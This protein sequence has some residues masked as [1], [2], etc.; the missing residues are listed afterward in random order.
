MND[1]KQQSTVTPAEPEAAPKAKKAKAAKAPAEP[2]AP[3][4]PKVKV[5]ETLL[6]ID[7]GPKKLFTG[8]RLTT[9]LTENPRKQG[10]VGHANFQH[11]ID[12]G[13]AG[14]TTEEYLEK[15]GRYVDLAWDYQRGRVNLADA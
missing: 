4:E 15:G 7:G 12:A 3:K 14:I 13:A 10:G 8:K 2:K 5:E 1:E 11:I 9:T 6:P